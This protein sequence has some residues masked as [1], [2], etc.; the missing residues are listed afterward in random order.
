MDRRDR[1]LA[2]GK[3]GIYR[4]QRTVKA[5]RGKFQYNYND[6]GT[7]TKSISSDGKAIRIHS[8]GDA[9]E[10]DC[11]MDGE[12]YRDMMAG[13]TNADEGILDDIA[14]YFDRHGRKRGERINLQED[15]APGHGYSSGRP[16]V[17]NP[18]AA[19]PTDAHEFW[20]QGKALRLLIDVYKQSPNSP[21]L[22]G[23]DLG[24]WSMLQAAVDDH[25]NEFLRYRSYGDLLDA[26]WDV[27]EKEFWAM[28]PAKLWTIFEHKKAVA[29]KIKQGGGAAMR[30]DP[31]SGCRKKLKALL[32][33]KKA[34]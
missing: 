12:V 18:W 9:V 15:G 5:G 7:K 16:T 6:D 11:T 1:P 33:E 22:N 3:I 29:E 27:I 10:I 2:H 30:K 17:E 23:L 31:H 14:A 26:L 13:R 25:A 21:E 8:K 24:V 28:E 20:A 34:R 19:T 32:A 4:S